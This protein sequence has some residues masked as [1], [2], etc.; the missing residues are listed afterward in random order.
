MT[1]PS[2]IDFKKTD[3]HLYKPSAK[4]PA[5]LEVPDLPYLMIDGQG[6]PQGQVFQQ[7]VKALYTLAYKIRMSHKSG[8]APAD[9]FEYVVPPL[10]GIWDIIPGTVYDPRDKTNFKWTLMIRQ[11]DFVT[12]DFVEKMRSIA[13]AVD[14]NPSLSAVRFDRQTDGLVCQMLH[15]GPFDDEPATFARM[16]AWA[17]EEGYRRQSKIHREIYL[18]DF[19]RTA[20]EK[21]KTVL[22]FKVE[23]R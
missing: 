9:Y 13:Q 19:N 4:K 1:S 5:I 15:M 18:S 17:E 7:A 10:E 8:H 16:E 2:K 22:R 20:P 21:L 14:D 12:P 23:K 11:P 6:A 3:K